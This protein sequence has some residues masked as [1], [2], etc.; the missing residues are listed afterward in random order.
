MKNLSSLVILTAFL[1]SA[2]A[3]GSSSGGP[4]VQF[5]K[6]LENAKQE[7][8]APSSSTQTLRRLITQLEIELLQIQSASLREM[9]GR[10]FGSITYKTRSRCGHPGP[11]G[12]CFSREYILVPV[13]AYKAEDMRKYHPQAIDSINKAMS[14]SK[15]VLDLL[16]EESK[17]T[18]YNEKEKAALEGVNFS[19]ALVMAQLAN[20]DLRLAEI[21]GQYAR[22][23]AG[24]SGH[25]EVGDPDSYK[26]LMEQTYKLIQTHYDAIQKASSDLSEINKA[27]KALGIQSSTGTAGSQPAKP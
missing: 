22:Q 8:L 2:H 1:G 15:S 17:K 13:L 6:A 18:V 27:D 24:M 9:A 7:A 5:S 10:P 3:G 4:D 20:S 23:V 12:T 25:V 21:H 14:S 26:K 11:G 19:L 16:Q